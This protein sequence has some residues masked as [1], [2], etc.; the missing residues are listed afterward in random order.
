MFLELF[1]NL[2]KII[3]CIYKY[4]PRIQVNHYT[5]HRSHALR[6]TFSSRIS[7]YL[8][9]FIF[10]SIPTSHP[11][12]AVEKHPHG[13]TTLHRRDGISQM[14]NS[15]W[16]SAQRLQF[17]SHQNRKSFSFL[18]STFSHSEVLFEGLKV[19]WCLP[20]LKNSPGCWLLLVFQLSRPPCSWEH[21]KLQKW[22]YS[23]ALIY[24]VPHDLLSWHAVWTAGPHIYTGVCLSI[25]FIC[26]N[27]PRLCSRCISSI[28]KA[29]CTWPQF[30]VPQQRVL[31]SS[32]IFGFQY[33]HRFLK[34]CFHFGTVDYLVL[35]VGQK[36]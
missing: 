29:G 8:A 5:S 24:Y 3:F 16:S 9:I 28:I 19:S 12:S 4:R 26:S 10:A 32:S 17:L 35:T 15:A 2:L 30:K 1:S 7:L 11:V 23:I 36:L 33:I 20:T 25:N 21:S 13:A 27:L 18:L 14:V 22:F 31:I 34:P 6:R